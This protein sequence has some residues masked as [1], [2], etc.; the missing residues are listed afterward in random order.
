M[1]ATMLG[2]TGLCVLDGKPG[3]AAGEGLAGVAARGGRFFGSAVRSRELNDEPKL[4]DAVLRECS[5]VVPEF[6]MNWNALEPAYGQLSFERMDALA[7]FGTTNGMK[8][9]GHTLLWHLGT[10][11]WAVDMLRERRDWNLIARYFGSVIPRY[12]DVI[13][14]WEVV[15]E[16][17]ETGHRTDGLRENVFLE[18][19]GPDYIRRAL[20]Q[21]R[22]FAPQAQL[23]INEYGLEY[24]LPLQRDRRYFL[25]KL[26][27]RLKYAGAPLDGLGLQAHLDLRNGTVSRSAITAFVKDVASLGLNM[28]VTELD[29]KEAAYAAPAESRDRMVADEVRRYLDIVLSHPAVRGVTTWGLSDLHSWLEVT[30]EDYARFPEAWTDGSG[31]GLNRGLPLDASMRPK[32]MYYAIRDAFLSARPIPQKR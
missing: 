9:R 10:P 29:V 22:S 1:L 24:D 13:G 4:R 7:A 31:P 21:A 23:I 11:D 17:I 26:L 28:V 3:S 15:N 30:K 18:V 32:P 12:G 5:H 25:L 6:E 14:R 2:V 16:P 20:M 19:F 8:V 27:E